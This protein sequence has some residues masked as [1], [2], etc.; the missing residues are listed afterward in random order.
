MGIVPEQKL[1]IKHT[2]L[3]YV[4]EEI[5]SESK[6]ARQRSRTEPVIDSDLL[7]GDVREL[8]HGSDCSTSLGD[9]VEEADYI[10]SLVP[11]TPEA[12]P[13][14]VAS[15]NMARAEE[16]SLLDYLPSACQ[17]GGW[18]YF[19]DQY[20][21]SSPHAVNMGMFNMHCGAD[22]LPA[23][24]STSGERYA[25]TLVPDF[26]KESPPSAEKVFSSANTH[27]V[28]WDDVDA[29]AE[30]RT[31]VML[32]SLPDTYTR[33]DL[34]RLLESEG[35]F[36]RFNFLYLPV[37]FKRNKNLGYALVNLVSASEA[38]RLGQHFE[39]FSR[40]DILSDKVCSVAWC[41]PQQG[42]EAH[43]E[44]YRNSPVMHE[45]V[46]EEWRPLLLAHGVPIVFPAPTIKIKAPRLKG[47]QQ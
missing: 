32:R 16:I 21:Q 10:E 9:S 37:D 38:L 23:Q 31:S 18:Q 24:F 7:Y 27:A 46:P 39:G 15:C 2:F 25:Y 42:L 17:Y 30:T 4:C 19:G 20:W 1:I 12:S 6:P 43:V 47:L 45:L 29:A 34:R 35:F 3:E 26:H 5:P 40:W 33:S 13:L 36:G 8:Y 14:R 44:R 28:D 11:A 22:Q 41:S